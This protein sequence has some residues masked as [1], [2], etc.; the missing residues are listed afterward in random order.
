MYNISVII[1][2]IEEFK[3]LNKIIQSVLNQNYQDFQVIV[4][5][6]CKIEKPVVDPRIQYINLYY[7][8]NI[9]ELLNK[10]I[11]YINT[12]LTCF[13]NPND[14]LLYNALELR[15]QKFRNNHALVA[16]YGFGFDTDCD[17]QVKCNHN[18]E[19][20]YNNENLPSNNL[21]SVLQGDIRP[22][23]SSLM[24]KT[25]ILKQ[26]CF[27]ENLKFN[28]DWDFFIKLFKSFGDNTYQLKEAI[29]LSKN[30]AETVKQYNKSFFIKYVKET[31]SI[32]DTFFEETLLYKPIEAK[33]KIYKDNYSR[34]F[35]A[36]TEHFPGD[37]LLRI[38]LLTSYIRKNNE[39]GNKILDFWFLSLLLNSLIATNKSEVLKNLNLSKKAGY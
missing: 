16:C 5:S 1:P 17:Y 8:K 29:Y 23:I 28:Y 4:V 32:L 37:H 7:A 34:F 25:E 3:D 24:I 11:N 6:N 10:S 31:L 35:T 2:V 20:F 26:L 14:L 30:E 33:Y 15:L 39:F 38:Y 22:T 9:P 13:I 19:Y 18:Y 21:K 27:N 36:L 12:E